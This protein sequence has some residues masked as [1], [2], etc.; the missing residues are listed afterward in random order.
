MVQGKSIS[1]TRAFNLSIAFACGPQFLCHTSP[2]GIG[3]LAFLNLYSIF[4]PFY[5]KVCKADPPFVS[6]T[7][8][9]YDMKLKDHKMF[10]TRVSLSLLSVIRFRDIYTN[11]P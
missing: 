9:I 8:C 4:S 3:F 5:L 7:L 10:L 2:R 6:A 11:A 1:L